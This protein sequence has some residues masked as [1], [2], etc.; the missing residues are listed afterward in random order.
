M[1]SPAL[2]IKA[3]AA[4]I[5]DERIQKAVGWTIVAV[6]SPLILLV[7][8]FCALGSG[9]SSHNVSAVEL[10][11]NGGTIPANVPAEY[12]ACLEEM[13]GKQ[14]L[15]LMHILRGRFRPGRIGEINLD[16]SI[17]MLS[18]EILP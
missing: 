11:F 14:I 16:R 1:A 2:L 15:G 18:E 6:L 4:L 9:T 17:S 7:A 10:C 13:Q 12:R 3:G 8:F 5:S